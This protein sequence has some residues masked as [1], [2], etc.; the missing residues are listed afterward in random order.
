MGTVGAL[1][2][3]LNTFAS[4]FMSE[5]GYAQFRLRQRAAKLRKEADEAV[6][7]DDLVTYA[8]LQSELE[9]LSNKP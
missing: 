5:A 9:Q 1:A 2:T 3:V 6:L 7:R 8:R 4:F